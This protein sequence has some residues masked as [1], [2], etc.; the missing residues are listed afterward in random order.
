MAQAVATALTHNREV[1]AAARHRDR[2]VR[3]HRRQPVSQPRPFLQPGQHRCGDA[4]RSIRRSHSPDRLARRS[5]TSA[6]AKRIDVPK[7]TARMRFLAWTGIAAKRLQVEDA[8][9]DRST[10][11]SGFLDGAAGRKTAAAVA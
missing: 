6:S 3:P 5:T 2:P 9:G 10:A 7:R 4:N 8:P 11:R 1:I